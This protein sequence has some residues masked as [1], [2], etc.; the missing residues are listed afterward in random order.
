MTLGVRVPPRLPDFLFRI[1]MKLLTKVLREAGKSILFVLLG[2]AVFITV[3]F[4]LF[5]SAGIFKFIGR[6]A[7]DYLLHLKMFDGSGEF[8]LGLI[9]CL[10]VLCFYVFGKLVYIEYLEKKD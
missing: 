7:N 9:S 5:L 3:G 1:I 8:V 2:C 4:G 10:M 6:L